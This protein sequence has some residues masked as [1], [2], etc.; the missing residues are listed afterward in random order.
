MF[1]A[2]FWV[3]CD[4]WIIP[5]AACSHA[6]VCPA[7]AP[8]VGAVDGCPAWCC[9]QPLALLFQVFMWCPGDSLLC[10]I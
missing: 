2:I 10:D 5:S 1:Y 6:P 4:G 9:L 3:K 8:A 7:L